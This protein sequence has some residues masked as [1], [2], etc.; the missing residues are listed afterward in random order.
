M[1]IERINCTI[2]CNLLIRWAFLLMA[3]HTFGLLNLLNR[4]IKPGI[5]YLQVY[6]MIYYSIQMLYSLIRVFLLQNY[7]LYN[8]IEL[9]Q[10]VQTI[11]LTIRTLSKKS[12]N[13]F[14][15]L[16]FQILKKQQKK[17]CQIAK[18]NALVQVHPRFPPPRSLRL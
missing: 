10:Q 4:L 14:L 1:K 9:E 18:R 6:I 17:N 16:F 2:K 7:E 12:K 11:C 8:F 13:S 5:I 15:E 3:P